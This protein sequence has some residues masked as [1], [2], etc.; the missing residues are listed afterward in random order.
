MTYLR[1][2]VQVY[3]EYANQ[4][5]A[6]PTT[7][8]NPCIVGPC[9]HIID[10][11]EDA[12][13]AYAGEFTEVGVEDVA[14]PNNSPGAILDEDSVALRL[15]SVLVTVAT[16]SVLQ[17]S[18]LNVLTFGAGQLPVGVLAG[19]YV[20]VIDTP[21]VGSPYTALAGARILSV[22]N[23]NNQISISKSVPTTEA[24]TVNFYREVADYE[25]EVGTAL[26]VDTVAGTFSVTP[27]TIDVAGASMLVYSAKLYFGYRAL[28]QDLS[29][30]NTIANMDELR[31]VLGKAV[32]ENPLGMAVAV[33]LA[34]T[35]TPVK[36]IG[37]D[38][39]DVAGYTAAKDR[40]ETVD[41]VYSVVPLTQE[42]EI[43]GIFK[44]HA[45][46]MSLPIEGKW[47]ICIG[48]TKLQT[49]Q[50]LQ[51]G[52][53]VATE[54]SLSRLRILQDSAA[55]FLSSQVDS[56]DTITVTDGETEAVLTVEAAIS[57]DMV[58][59]T[60]DMSLALGSSYAYTITRTLD[61]T[62]QAKAVGAVSN[63]FGSSRFIH[64][65]PDT[66]FVDGNELP[67]YYLACSV[68]GMT[69][70]LPSHQGFTR[71]SIAGIGGLKH[72]NEYFNATQ[73][74]IIADGG[75]FI[76]VQ[77]SLSAPPAVRHQLTTD[78]ST[79][80]FRELSFVKNFDYVS[81]ICRGV[82][83]RYLGR[84][85]ITPSTLATL[86]TAIR[87]TMESLKLSSLP[88]IGSPVLGYEIV[89]VA[90]LEDIRDRVEMYVEVDFPYVLNTIGLHL[91]SR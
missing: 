9:F 8:L 18:T 6:T 39:E 53:A 43:L 80:E 90:Q 23:V 47:R 2:L 48:S 78:M 14:I 86:E 33:T 64:V 7:A 77:E 57:E 70:G 34:N 3:Q 16:S 91:I 27:Q 11:L 35:T 58:A 73:L 88:R 42:S 71:I 51:E 56:G 41:D 52:T 10:N 69:G 50:T 20:E 17:S 72:A 49:V 26:T 65:W 29:T 24:P 63:A 1:P 79:I 13:L 75:T 84:Y 32:P 59:V 60:T 82:L 83:D 74:D 85:N 81:I 21:A 19:D 30:I 61:K 28:R 37:V 62:E 12:T 38:S 15:S 4:S 25:L 54:D 66:C 45:E 46:Q 76:F 31:G 55:T 67:G 89:S 5:I 68:A 22:D 87:G 36:A 44:Q 40:L